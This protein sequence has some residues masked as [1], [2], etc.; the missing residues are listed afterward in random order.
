MLSADLLIF[1][2]IG[3]G[4][5]FDATKLHYPAAPD[6]RDHLAGWM[7]KI[8]ELVRGDFSALYF[9]EFGLIL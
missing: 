2:S 8:T 7:P 6:D 3:E 1:T 5:T 9:F 4:F